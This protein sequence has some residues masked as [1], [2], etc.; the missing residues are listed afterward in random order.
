MTESKSIFIVEDHKTNRENLKELLE[1][2]KIPVYTFSSSENFLEFYSKQQG[3]LI[4]DIRL[5]GLSGIKL[6]EKLQ[7]DHH[8]PP[9]KIIFLTGRGDIEM[10]VNAIKKG[11]CDF[12]TKPCKNQVLLDKVYEHLHSK[13]SK[14]SRG[15]DFIQAVEKKYADLSPREKEVLQQLRLGLSSKEIGKKLH[16]S[17]HTVEVHRANLMRKTESKSIA[18]LLAKFS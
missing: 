3:V 2:F 6:F 12:L 10:A 1:I 11:A 18:Q 17:I 14:T 13:V 5:P 15:K 7:Q 8:N 4:L 9:L 16:I